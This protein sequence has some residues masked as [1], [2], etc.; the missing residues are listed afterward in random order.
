MQVHLDDGPEAQRLQIDHVLAGHQH[1]IKSARSKA[2]LVL[3]LQRLNWDKIDDAPHNDI[4]KRNDIED[5]NEP[6]F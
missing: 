5:F 3:D 1:G 2:R 6:P 4:I